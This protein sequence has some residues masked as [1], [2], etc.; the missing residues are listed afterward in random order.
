MRMVQKNKWIAEH[1]EELVDEYGG[2]YIAVVDDPKEVEDESVLKH[3]GV[4]PS[5]LKVPKEEE[6]VCLL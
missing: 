2:L 5:V 1:F 3:P 4:I 6:I